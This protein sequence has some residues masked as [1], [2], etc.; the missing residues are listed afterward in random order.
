M[1]IRTNA[2]ASTGARA[3]LA[4]SECL[5]QGVVSLVIYLCHYLPLQIVVSDADK[6]SACSS[7][8][9]HLISAPVYRHSLLFHR[10][11][12]LLAH[13]SHRATQM[14]FCGFR[15]ARVK[16]VRTPCVDLR[17]RNII[18]SKWIISF[19]RIHYM[20]IWISSILY[21]L[22]KLGSSHLFTHCQTKHVYQY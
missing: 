13:T 18:D 9:M 3:S 6:Y 11:S 8:R 5:E 1:T 19:K 7:P 20:M 21:F 14:G 17:N 10:S 15:N 22:D 4:L 12:V 2:L 16:I